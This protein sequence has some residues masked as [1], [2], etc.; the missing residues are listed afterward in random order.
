ME[1]TP[2]HPYD[3]SVRLSVTLPVELVSSL[4]RISSYSGLTIS[5]VIQ[6]F[7]EDSTAD[8]IALHIAEVLKFDPERLKELPPYAR[9]ALAKKRPTRE[10]LQ[11]VRTQLGQLVPGGVKV[12]T[13]KGGNYV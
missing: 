3:T 6:I 7:L 4:L 10:N 8:D 9:K 11:A 13:Y 2:D 12:D 1:T 5:G